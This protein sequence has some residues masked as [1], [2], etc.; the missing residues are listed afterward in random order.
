MI[1]YMK[2]EPGAP[3]YL[4]RWPQMCICGSQKGPM[5]DSFLDKPGYGGRQMQDGRIYVCRLCAKRFGMAF[6]IVKG[7]EM[8]R[9]EAASDQLALAQQQIEERQQLIDR[10]AATLGANEAKINTQREFI[11]QLQGELQMHKHAQDQAVALLKTREMVA[12]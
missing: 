5:V 8:E 12:A 7:P 4:E 10:M 9:L 3:G 1:E 2:L 11:E 6:G